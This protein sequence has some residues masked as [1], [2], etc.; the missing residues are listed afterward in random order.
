[1][2]PRLLARHVASGKTLGQA[3]AW[4]EQVDE[5]NAG[6][7]EAARGRADLLLDLT[8]WRG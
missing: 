7:V 3:R 2:L 5:A 4:V 8:R 1:M 6:L